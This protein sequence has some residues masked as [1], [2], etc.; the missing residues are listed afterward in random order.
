MF[1][2][3]F[4]ESLRKFPCLTADPTVAGCET[5]LQYNLY[6]ASLI[7][8]SNVVFDR[9]NAG[10]VNDELMLISKLTGTVNPTEHEFQAIADDG[11]VVSLTSD[12]SKR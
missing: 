9:L 5:D 12:V 1:L 2:S 4:R 8:F 3:L 7:V 6:N 11:N 10:T